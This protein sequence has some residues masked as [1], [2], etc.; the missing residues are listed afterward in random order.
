MI[1]P[2]VAYFG[3]KDYQQ[4]L[5][6]RQLVRDLDMPVRI[7]VCPTVRDPDGLALSSRNAYLTRPERQRALALKAALDAAAERIAQGS[8]PDEARAA[9]LA[10]LDNAG[11]APEYLEVLGAGDLRP[12]RCEPGEEVVIAVAARVGGARLI[13]NE[14]VKVP[15]KTAQP[16]IN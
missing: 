9:A 11:I 15:A 8:P 7:V 2:D 12:P 1:A 4:T 16:A 10:E 13:D 5:V 6:I 14:L 3:Q